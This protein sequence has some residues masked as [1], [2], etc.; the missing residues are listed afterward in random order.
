MC[1]HFLCTER[2][3]LHTALIT[4]IDN[5]VNVIRTDRFTPLTQNFLLAHKAD[6]PDTC[7]KPLRK[8]YK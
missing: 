3:T 7:M 6:D 8:K 1:R 5:A 4:R 2:F